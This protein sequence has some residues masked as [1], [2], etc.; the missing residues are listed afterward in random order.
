MS[1]KQTCLVKIIVNPQ[2][3]KSFSLLFNS[4]GAKLKIIIKNSYEIW[5]ILDN[6]KKNLPIKFNFNIVFNWKN[7]PKAIRE[8]K[9]VKDSIKK[10]L[11]SE[12]C[13]DDYL[14]YSEIIKNYIQTHG[15]APNFKQN[16]KKKDK[17]KIY[18]YIKSIIPNSGIMINDALEIAKL[19]NLEPNN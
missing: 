7:T 19:I 17:L 8:N 18:N 13:I 6:I 5:E 3:D 10:I 11:D 16:T 15:S 4:N 2:L 1:E 14:K 9:L 12:N